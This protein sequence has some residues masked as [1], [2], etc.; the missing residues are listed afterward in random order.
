[1]EGMDQIKTYVFERGHQSIHYRRASRGMR[2]AGND[3][4]QGGYR[5]S[6][7]RAG[8]EPSMAIVKE[9]DPVSG[10]REAKNILLSHSPQPPASFVPSHLTG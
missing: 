6:M 5:T 8:Y 9:V 7:Q 4:R 3:E 1:M 10:N 2:F